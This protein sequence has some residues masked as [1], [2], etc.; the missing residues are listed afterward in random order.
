MTSTFSTSTT[1]AKKRNHSI[2][3]EL[4]V[5]PTSVPRLAFSSTVQQAW[6]ILLPHGIIPEQV[7]GVRSQDDRSYLT[8]EIPPPMP[9]SSCEEPDPRHNQNT[10]INQ[11]VLENS[12]SNVRRPLYNNTN[13]QKIYQT[14]QTHIPHPLITEEQPITQK[15]YSRPSRDCQTRELVDE[16]ERTP[17]QSEKKSGSSLLSNGMGRIL[18]EEDHHLSEADSDEDS[19]SNIPEKSVVD[20]IFSDCSWGQKVMITKLFAIIENKEERIASLEEELGTDRAPE[21]EIVPRVIYFHRVYCEC[22]QD[23]FKQD[24]RKSVFLDPPN[25][26]ITRKRWHL[27]GK[28]NAPDQNVFLDQNMDVVLLVYKDYR[29]KDDSALYSRP[30]LIQNNATTIEKNPPAPCSE[31]M[32]INSTILFEALSWATGGKW[33]PPG[34]RNPIMAPYHPLY[35]NQPPLRQQ[36][37]RMNKEQQRYVAPAVDYIEQSFEA[38]LQE[39]K[40]LFS[41][42][43]VSLK[44]LPYLFVP[45]SI[46]I[47]EKGEEIVAYRTKSWLKSLP[48][49][50]LNEVGLLQCLLLVFDGQYFRSRK[51]EFRL[52]WPGSNHE[53]LQIRTLPIYP[54]EYAKSSLEDDLLQRG[55]NFWI[56]RERIYVN[57]MDPELLGD[58]I[59]R[60]AR[61]MIDVQMHKFMDVASYPVYNEDEIVN[62]NTDPSSPDFLLLMPHKIFGFSM[63]SKKWVSLKVA[64]ITPVVW[65][66]EA[67]DS[68]VVDGETKELVKALV[69]NQITKEKGTDLIEGKGNGLVILLHGW[70]SRHWQDPYGSVAELARKPLYRVT[71]GDIGT[72]ADAIE[73]HLQQVLHLGRVWG[74]VVLLDEAD[75]FLEERSLADMQRNALVS[76]FLRVLEYYDGILVLTSNRVGT[77]DEAFKS[78]IQL[79][80][81]YEN[82]DRTQRRAIWENFFKRLE[83]IDKDAVDTDNLRKYLDELA[84]HDMN[85]RQIRNSITTA[86]QLARYKEIKMNYELLKHAIKVG[87]KFDN[88]L[89][90]VKN[91]ISYDQ[92]AREDGVR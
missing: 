22:G 72:N 28:S 84:L 88:Y 6:G 14:H 27:R 19:V 74:C 25:R 43:L 64:W 62:S 73:K 90:A 58:A 49:P 15:E 65:N 92:L 36:L 21:L 52:Q 41:Q 83:E 87:S 12:I 66:R 55:G 91:N 56:C 42:G 40:S 46:V 71:C 29:C 3:G 48:E 45:D 75:V 69:T 33:R 44:T 8:R 53:N 67:F 47:Q 68:L 70:E 26:F 17:L 5:P 60:S 57:Y 76:V 89:K 24:F 31:S 34:L 35:Y 13:L 38:N 50:K 16:Q 7:N 80:L 1:L 86:R 54:L 85:G 81:H 20:E 11:D 18:D 2:D 23:D 61:Y 10:N 78:R 9:H 79:A 59:E 4:D 39:A 77:F 32:M 30:G 37:D 63:Q 82:L 51:T